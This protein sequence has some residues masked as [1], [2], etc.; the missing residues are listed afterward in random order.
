MALASLALRIVRRPDRQIIGGLASV[1]AY[2]GLRVASA[3]L[4]LKLSAS[5]LSVEAFAV[6]TQFLLFVSLLNLAAVAGMQNGLIR[7]AAAASDDASLAR[8]RSGAFMIWAGAIPLLIVPVM[9]FSGAIS[10]VLAGTRAHRV[11]VIAIALLALAAGPAQIWCSILSGRKR[12]ASSLGAQAIGLVAGTGAAAWMIVR[13]DAVGA[14]IGFACGWIVTMGF[15]GLFAAG[16]R[17]GFASPAASWVQVRTLLRYSAA[18]AATAGFTAIVLFGLRF[19]YRESFGAEALGYWMAANRISDMSTQLLGLFMIQ[20]FVPHLATIPDGTARRSFVLRCWAAGAAIMAGGFLL[21]SLA[22]TPLVHLFLS[23]AYL[24]AI[25]FIRAYVLGD[26]CRVAVSLAMFSAFAAGRPARYAAIEIATLAL[27]AAIT[28]A[29]ISAGDSRAPT[30]G[31]VGAYAVAAAII[32]LTFLLR[33]RHATAS[34][35]LSGSPGQR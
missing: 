9:L 30:F 33:G 7:Q 14:V 19:V 24:P 10:D 17:I 13:G 2:F 20:F 35:S 12:V 18:F 6:F 23:D 8:V 15:A 1:P 4:L 3:L 28:L 34:R 27:M 16:L 22:S 31:Y 32:A 5:F 26:V 21:F 25:P 11:A 29:L